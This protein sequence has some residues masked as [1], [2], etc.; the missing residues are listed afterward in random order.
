MGELLKA[1]LGKTLA[2]TLFVALSM[3]AC[4]PATTYSASNCDIFS[5]SFFTFL[6]SADK[7]SDPRGYF[8]EALAEQTRILE[9]IQSLSPSTQEESDLISELEDLNLKLQGV[10]QK[11]MDLRVE[12]QT[13]LEFQNSMTEEELQDWMADGQEASAITAASMKAWENYATYCG[14]TQ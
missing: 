2:A 8:E 1:K 6:P 7:Q 10:Y 11:Q 14:L 5:D 12:G 13:A 3:T 4:S 9:K